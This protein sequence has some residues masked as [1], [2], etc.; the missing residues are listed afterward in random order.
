MA[1]PA[2]LY[3]HVNQTSHISGDRLRV[4]EVDAEGA[5][6][7]LLEIY[8]HTTV[9]IDG[10]AAPATWER[11]SA[12][13][14]SI[15]NSGGTATLMSRI[16]AVVQDCASED[17]FG[18]T[19]SLIEAGTYD[20]IRL[21]TTFNGGNEARIDVTGVADT[22]NN[23]RYE[24]E[25]GDGESLPAAVLHTSDGE[26]NLTG[27]SAV[28]DQSRILL[29]EWSGGSPTGNRRAL[30]SNDTLAIDRPIHIDDEF[31]VAADGEMA[32]E[33]ALTV[34]AVGI[35]TLD[36]GS[37]VRVDLPDDDGTS[38]FEVRDSGGGVMFSIDSDGNL[39]KAGENFIIE[40]TT[41]RYADGLLLLNKDQSGGTPNLDAGFIAERGTLNNIFFGWD[42]SAD[43]IVFADIGDSDVGD[44]STVTPGSYVA[45]RAGAATFTGAVTVTDGQNFLLGGYTV[46]DILDEDDLSSDSATAL[47]TQQ[48]IKAY[49]DSQVGGVAQTL[50]GLTDT[51]ITGPADLDVLQWD[52]GSS[53]WV[54]RSLSEAGIQAQD[55]VL[56]DLAALN[57]VAADQIIVGNGAG[58][59]TY[60]TATA[61]GLAL[62]D[63]A[64]ASAQRTTLGLGSVAT[65]GVLDEDDLNSDSDTDVPTQ[66]SVKAYVDAQITGNNTI[67]EMTD[68]TI[69]GPAD[70]DVLQWDNGSSKW[71]DRSLA[72]AGIQA[73]DDLLDSIAGLATGADLGIYL[74][75]ED[76]AATFTLT[77]AGRAIL[78]DADAAAQRTTLGLGQTASVTFDSLTL[79][80]TIDVDGV[81]NLDDVDIDGDTV[82]AS[83]KEIQFEGYTAADTNP[84]ANNLLFVME[85]DA[86]TMKARLPNPSSTGGSFLLSRI[87]GIWRTGSK[88]VRFG[89]ANTVLVEDGVAINPGDAL[90]ASTNQK[91]RV[92][93]FGDTGAPGAGEWKVFVGYA[94]GAVADAQTD[95]TV[96]VDLA[97]AEPVQL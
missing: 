32:G 14:Y 21:Y 65:Y 97:L 77:A 79:G 85:D 27:G 43:E 70:L 3:L 22:T 31:K 64:D 39:T 1:A 24:S 58:T 89:R 7:D 48:S 95:A 91:G 84:A 23:F 18:V 10:G 56:D 36:G 46:N 83:G 63:D 5:D 54:D 38:K 51:T 66:Q 25:L 8:F 57:V 6:G 47:A 59:F 71:V 82:I 74:T 33:G 68:T 94:I 80:D 29:E 73:Q 78:D 26:I 4:R 81:A 69:T 72:E 2:D 52:N 13:R 30:G 35:L 96:A 44:G 86:G 11:N 92:T 45:I 75:A 62:L 19:A 37:H 28:A 55:D 17:G 12:H 50:S 41:V 53:K 42:E 15:N 93:V 76:T 60:A 61:A 87:N 40:G 49:V 20:R 90:Y 16:V 9:D 34:S 88:A 67:A